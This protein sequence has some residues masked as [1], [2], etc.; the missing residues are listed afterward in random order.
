MH[1]LMQA[2]AARRTTVQVQLYQ[3]PWPLLTGWANHKKFVAAGAMHEGLMAFERGF[4]STKPQV[5]AFCQNGTILWVQAWVRA[6]TI[7]RILANPHTYPL[8]EIDEDRE[9]RSI[10]VD[11]F[12]FSVVYEVREHELVILGLWHQHGESEDWSSREA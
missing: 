7:E 4:G 6:S 3:D 10:S 11:K 1:P 12:P 2:G 8:E 5:A 9:I